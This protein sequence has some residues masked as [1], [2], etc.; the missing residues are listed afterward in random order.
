MQ[1]VQRFLMSVLGMVVLAA[2]TA[3]APSPTATPEPTPSPSPSPTESLEAELLDRRW[4]VLFVGTDLNA[5]REERGEP[6]NADALMLV[7]LSAD[8]SELTLVS[9]PRDTVD[10]PLADGGV[11]ERK[12]NALYLDEGIDTLVGA[13]ETL[14]DV[15]IDGHVVLDMDDFT[16]LVDAVGG[17]EVAPDEPIEDPIVNL[18]LDAGTQEIDAATANGYVRTRVDKDYGRMGRQQEVL[19]AIAERLVDPE[20]DV[21][22]RSLAENLD[23]LETDLPLDEIPTLLELARRATDAEVRRLLIEPP[24]ITFEGDRGDGRGYILEADVEAIRD[25]VGELIRD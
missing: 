12:I 7:S 25:E 19:L 20:T 10:V 16:R 9:L 1:P 6:P 5:A 14:F 18:D 2:C 24:L 3:D 8:Q 23:S 13:M 4:T 17:V 15:P 11:W 22:V 21:D